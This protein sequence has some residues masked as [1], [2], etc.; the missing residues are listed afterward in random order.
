MNKGGEKFAGVPMRSEAC[1]E[2]LNEPTRVWGVLLNSRGPLL[3]CLSGR[4]SSVWAV[5]LLPVGEPFEVGG[6]DGYSDDL[7]FL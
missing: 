5:L 1:S 2:R 4:G 3:V 6:F 7:A